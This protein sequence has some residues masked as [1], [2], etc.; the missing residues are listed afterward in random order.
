MFIFLK[1]HWKVIQTLMFLREKHSVFQLLTIC[2]LYP[3][4]NFHQWFFTMGF[5]GISIHKITRVFILKT[6]TVNNTNA[7]VY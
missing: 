7:D 6:M 4:T 1:P 5:S 3:K 2:G